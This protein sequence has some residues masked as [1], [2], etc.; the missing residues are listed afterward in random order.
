MDGIDFAP[1]MDTIYE[2]ETEPGQYGNYNHPYMN[3]S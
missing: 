1:A 3:N 2:E